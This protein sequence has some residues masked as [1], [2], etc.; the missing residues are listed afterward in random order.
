MSPYK[1][2]LVFCPNKKRG[3]EIALRLKRDIVKNFVC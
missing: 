1:Y 2:N 3:V